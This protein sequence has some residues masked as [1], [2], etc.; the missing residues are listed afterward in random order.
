M[1][2]PGLILVTGAGGGVADVGGKV[3]AL[4]RE[5][6][7][8]VRAMHVLAHAGFPPYVEEHIA[9]VARLHRENRYDRQTDTV[10]EITG[11][12]AESVEHFVAR[13][14]DLFAE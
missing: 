5:R 7:R 13:R 12:P 3:V 6:G 4:L 10:E 11:R 9:T 2:E 8:A 14:R 1:A